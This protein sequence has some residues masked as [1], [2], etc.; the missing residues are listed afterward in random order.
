MR[1]PTLRNVALSAPYM[2]DGR[3]ATLDA[4]IEH[5]STIGSR[6][7][8]HDR[9]LP[10]ARF[11]AGERAELLSFLASLSDESFV[12]RFAAAPAATAA[13]AHE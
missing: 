12:R 5:Y 9:R 11:S 3:F 8:R 10:H 1:V 13:P 4:V 6:A 7:G 2:H